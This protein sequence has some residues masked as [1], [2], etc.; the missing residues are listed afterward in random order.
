MQKFE[1]KSAKNQFFTVLGAS[2]DFEI[3][4]KFL[5]HFKSIAAEQLFITI[6]FQTKNKKNFYSTL[7]Y[8]SN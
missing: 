5:Y 4:D 3:F 8:S 1:K 6:V 7:A 2:E